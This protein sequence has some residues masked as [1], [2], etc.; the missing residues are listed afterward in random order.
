M[1]A[2]VI[3]ARVQFGLARMAASARRQ[4]LADG[5]AQVEVDLE[6]LNAELRAAMRSGHGFAAPDTDIE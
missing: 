2:H 3:D 4:V 5:A 6:L 1:S